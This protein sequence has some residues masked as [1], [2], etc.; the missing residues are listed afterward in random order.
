MDERA[1]GARSHEEVEDL[2]RRLSLLN[3]QLTEKTVK[4]RMFEEEELERKDQQ[5]EQ[6][7]LSVEQ[8]D[9]ELIRLVDGLSKGSDAAVSRHLAQLQRE[10]MSGEEGPSSLLFVVSRRSTLNSSR[11]ANDQL[12]STTQ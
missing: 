9:L 8:K 12:S 2:R 5:I 11:L 7:V 3:E 6:L 1:R 4:V 10:Q